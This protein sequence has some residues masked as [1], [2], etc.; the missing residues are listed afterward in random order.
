LRTG[1]CHN[2]R[3]SF[4]GEDGPKM[5]A[6]GLTMVWALAGWLLIPAISSA[7]T[8]DARLAGAPGNCNRDCE[9]EAK[10]LIA[11]CIAN[12]GGKE[13][14]NAAGR[15]FL[16]QCKV[17]CNDV[18]PCEQRCR[19]HAEEAL[20]ECLKR[21]GTQ[22]ACAARA[23]EFFGLCVQEH[24]PPPSCEDACVERARHV[25]GEC[26][27][28]GGNEQECG[29]R[30]RTFLLHCVEEN[31]GIPDCARRCEVAAHG[32]FQMCIDA[33]GT[34]EECHARAREFFGH[35]VE[36]H[37]PPPPTCEN[38]C[39]AKARHVL[40]ECIAT[41]VREETC[42]QRAREFLARC[43][44][45]NC[46]R[47]PTC[48]DRCRANAEGVFRICIDNGVSEE[49][50]RTIAH[51]FLEWCIPMQ[52]LHFCNGIAG[53]PC[54]KG[55][56]CKFPPGTCHIQDNQGVCTPLPGACPEYYDPVC[57]CDGKTYSNEC[58]AYAAGVSIAHL[59]PC[60]AACRPADNGQGCTPAPCSAIP[61]VQCIGTVL[62][63]DVH[64]GAITTLACECVDLNFCHI[65]FGNASPFAVGSCPDGGICHVIATD[66]DGDGIDD[67]FRAGC[68]ST[69]ACCSDIGGSP[70]PVP[71]CTE[72]PADVCMNSGIFLGVGTTCG[73]VEACCVVAVGTTGYCVE[74]S[75]QCCVAMG[76][77]PQGP[78][79]FCG[80]PTI[81]NVCSRFCG[82]FTGV[83]CDAGEFCKFPEGV[84]SDA[85]DHPGV[86]TPIPTVCPDV[87][88]PV[89]GCD[90]AT[91]GNECEAA[92][93]GVSIDHPGPC[94]EVCGGIGGFPCDKGEFCKFPPGTCNITDNQGLCTPI[95]TGCPD[96]LDPVCGCNGVTY[97]N[98]CE[99]D[100]ASVS[101]A[102][103]G[104]CEGI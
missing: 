10:S 46:S 39:E 77:E 31:C 6:R 63:L 82:G 62:H 90:G 21:G 22:E 1:A 2:F 93:A 72:V 75:R 34:E 47:P 103:R 4:H 96:H 5:K 83:T 73:S 68:D 49:L 94:R 85:A 88:A 56:F 100:A 43:I 55:E 69:G 23:R 13:E 65:E 37:C 78:N 95:P 36:E 38:E 25:F 97:F 29:L 45:E 18:P 51:E 70:L 79:S 66:S 84:C 58:F 91:Y 9:G 54:D 81:P 48:E 61:E 71:I 64:T 32:V 87:R 16:H 33:G 98:P 20:K 42:A 19:S 92:A 57:G 27:A 86:C 74:I 12:G 102:H 52:C 104:A 17:K 60:E 14:C 8:V 99:A 30:A 35:C 67:T 50:C 15:A 41:G 3:A 80:D 40:N 101:I 44:K 53:L 26:V 59:G 7:D 24:C 76:G 11:A 89:C 28:A